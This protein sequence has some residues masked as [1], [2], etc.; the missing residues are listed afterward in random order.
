MMARYPDKM[1]VTRIKCT[2]L[3]IRA[4]SMYDIPMQSFYEF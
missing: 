3:A 4:I 2:S 1:H